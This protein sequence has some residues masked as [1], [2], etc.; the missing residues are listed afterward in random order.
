MTSE[1]A[2]TQKTTSLSPEKIAL[3]KRTIAK[4][5]TDDELALFIG[6]CERT[7]LDPMSRQIYAI[8][9]WD[10]TERREVMAT[11]VSIDGFRLI[12]ERTGKYAGQLGPQWCGP[13]GAWRDVWLEDE[14]PA[15]AR[16]GVL[17][18]DFKE[19]L[20]AVARFKSYA[21]TKKD[22]SLTRMWEQMGDLMIAKC[23]EGLG[24]RRAFPQELS[25]LYTTEEMQ[26]AGGDIVDVEV[27]PVQPVRPP[28][29]AQPAARPETP[30]E[31]AE[32]QVKAAKAAN[33]VWMAWRKADDAVLWAVDQTDADGTELF[34]HHNH[35][36]ASFNKAK[37]E[38]GNSLTD[39]EKP[40][41]DD[42][43]EAKWAH[44]RALFKYFYERTEAKK[45]GETLLL[46]TAGTQRIFEPFDANEA[47]GVEAL[48]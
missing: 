12:A 35:A 41:P 11:Q 16:T 21:Q 1:L 5:A 36:Q 29:P 24:L 43:H 26:Q 25:G 18:S 3:L 48:S 34:N 23:S 33:T 47:V 6:Q 39:A 20:W 30:A 45:R 37:E 40:K 31:P 9:R 17:R 8:K 32:A 15:A 46:P 10:S 19:P 2:T 27:S 4:G 42:P 44:T 28:E 7:G 13:D 14:P 38:Y 22:G